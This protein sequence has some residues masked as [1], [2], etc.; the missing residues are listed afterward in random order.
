MKEKFYKN[1]KG[2]FIRSSMAIDVNKLDG[3]EVI[4]NQ[5]DAENQFRETNGLERNDGVYIPAVF[6][7][8]GVIYATGLNDCE[9]PIEEDTAEQYI[10]QYTV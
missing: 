9:F 2:Y 6:E 4:E 10:N 3:V 8:N 1:K 7:L 5:N